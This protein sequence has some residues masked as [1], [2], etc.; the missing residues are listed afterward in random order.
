MRVSQYSGVTDAGSQRGAGLGGDVD[1]GH[2]GALRRE[3]FHHRGP[4]AGAAA[5]HEHAATFEA[6]EARGV[7]GTGGVLHDGRN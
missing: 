7:H 6:G 3:G 5:G 1:E 2:Q 4:D